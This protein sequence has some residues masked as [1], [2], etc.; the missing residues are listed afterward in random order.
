MGQKWSIGIYGGPS[1]L[2][3]TCWLGLESGIL[4]AADVTDAEA[5][6]V[7]D[8]FMFYSEGI[9][10]LFFEV[11]ETMHRRGSIGL[12]QSRDLRQWHYKQIVIREPYHLSYPYVFNADGT[13]Y[14]LVESL[15]RDSVSLYRADRF[16]TEWSF[17]TSLIAGAFAD[18]S[19]VRHD[20]KWW[21]FACPSPYAHDVL[22]LFSTDRLDG[23]WREHPASPLITADAQRA[24]PAGRVIV[25]EGRLLRYA[26]DCTPFY[27]SNVRAF[28]I[29]T[30]TDL[31]YAEH[32]V[33]QSPVFR[34]GAEGWNRGGMHH[35]DAHCLS[36]GN[37]VA[38]VDGWSLAEA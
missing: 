14:M 24:R 12:A 23:R 29:E 18:P 34:P 31:D 37:W 13:F 3:L 11:F 28:S 25:W 21:L 27:G 5:D 26:Q 8:P 2:L 19:I 9:W 16:P 15:D 33:P 17:M 1:P 36:P 7:A 4:H 10:C 32:E 38:C 20:G 22:Q 6:F 35:V 30:L